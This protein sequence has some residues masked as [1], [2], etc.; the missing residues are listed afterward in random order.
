MSVSG[1]ELAWLA[2]QSVRRLARGRGG[3]T[4]KGWRSLVGSEE[5]LLRQAVEGPRSRPR[6]P[7]WPAG[8]DGRPGGRG[9]CPEGP[10]QASNPA[11]FVTNLES[12]PKTRANSNNTGT[13]WPTGYVGARARMARRLRRAFASAGHGRTPR[14][15][16]QPDPPARRDGHSGAG[17]NLEWP[18]LNGALNGSHQ[19]PK[20]LPH[21]PTTSLREL[22]T[23]WRQKT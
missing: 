14:P 18:K 22:V 10:S 17:A 23:T 16:R 11:Q 21:R 12:T 3:P 1:E 9:L 20:P 6:Q 5:P 2:R 19:Q 4:C 15:P 8:R 13:R 7:D